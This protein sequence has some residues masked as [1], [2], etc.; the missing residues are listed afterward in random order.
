MP[1]IGTVVNMVGII[2][3]T[4]VGILLLITGILN[5]TIDL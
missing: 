2:A 5:S 3:G 4:I 1:G